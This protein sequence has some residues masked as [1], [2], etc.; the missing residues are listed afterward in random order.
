MLGQPC[1]YPKSARLVGMAVAL[2]WLV[3]LGICAYFGGVMFV[4]GIA[5]GWGIAV[6][7][8]SVRSPY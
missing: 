4:L 6:M 8:I 3:F 1:F 7:I 5:V 2:A